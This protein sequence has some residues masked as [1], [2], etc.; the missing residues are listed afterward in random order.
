MYQHKSLGG[1]RAQPVSTLPP[2]TSVTF[3]FIVTIFS[4]KQASMS[5]Y[6]LKWLCLWQNCHSQDHARRRGQ[7][8]R[9]G[10]L[11][12]CNFHD[13][14][15]LIAM[16]HQGNLE[17]LNDSNFPQI[18]NKA[19]H[20]R[21]QRVSFYRNKYSYMILARPLLCS[22]YILPAFL[23]SFTPLPSSPNPPFFEEYD[24]ICKAGFVSFRISSIFLYKTS[25]FLG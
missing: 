8:T 3:F 11:Q 18:G 21:A 23:P 6:Y 19:Y 17:L 5:L 13:S 4:I 7:G 24:S 22:T 20:C 16:H 9:A 14:H 25:L 1:G 2:W 12:S 10:S 15:H